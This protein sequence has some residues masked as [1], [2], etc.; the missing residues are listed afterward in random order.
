[1]EERQS[2]QSLGGFEAE[3]DPGDQP[4]LGIGRLDQPVGEV[5]FDRGED[6]GAVFDDA[7]LGCHEG[8]DGTAAGPADPPL[9]SL[10]GGVVRQL[11]H[12]PQ[13]FFEE[14]GPIQPGIRVSDP[15]ELDRR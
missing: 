9:E 8:G 2:D 6:P 1:M 4:D 3:R 7:P 11:E 5:V 13:A 15:G 14:V 10:G 12:G